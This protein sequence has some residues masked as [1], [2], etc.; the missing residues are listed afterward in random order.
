MQNE[1]K[2]LKMILGI[3]TETGVKQIKDV[4]GWKRS[5][6]SI[7]IDCAKGQL[8]YPFASLVLG[9]ASD[10]FIRSRS[11]KYLKEDYKPITDAVNLF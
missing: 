11:D 4:T 8:T 10:G 2:L 5:G 6:D 3:Q 7:V 1:R 9:V